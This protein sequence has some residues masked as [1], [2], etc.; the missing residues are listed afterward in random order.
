MKFDYK[1]IQID[2]ILLFFVQ[3]YKRIP[4][5]CFGIRL[6]RLFIQHAAIVPDFFFIIQI[7]VLGDAP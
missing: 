7:A 3:K 6:Y 5:S 4:K 2:Y 1:K